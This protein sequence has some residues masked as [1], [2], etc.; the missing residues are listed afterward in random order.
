MY[1]LTIESPYSFILDSESDSALNPPLS[2][3]QGVLQW[4]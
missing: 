2:H 3:G 4:V 1:D